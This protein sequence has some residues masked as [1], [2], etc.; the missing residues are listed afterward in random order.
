MSQRAANRR[1]RLVGVALTL[2][3]AAALTKAAWVQ[4]GQASQFSRRA[5]AQQTAE[6]TIEASRGSI[7]DRNNVELASNTE[8]ITIWADPKLVRSPATA[9][10]QAARVLGLKNREEGKLLE[11]LADRS[12][13]FVYV[14]RQVPPETAARLERLKI[15]GF[16]FD[17]DP[18]RSYPQR[19]LAAQVLGFTD[20]DSRGIAGLEL[21]YN[22]Q[23]TGKDGSQIVER[24]PKGAV[25]DVLSTEDEQPGADLTLT[26]DN[27]IQLGVQN[28]LKK[29]LIDQGARSASAV[30][31]DAHSGAVLAMET[32]PSYDANETSKAPLDRQR[33]RAVTDNYEPGSTFKLVTVAGALA[34]G[35]VSPY[36]RFT[37]PYSIPVAD[38]TIHDAHWR[39]TERMSVAEILSESSNV[40]AV[41]I[42]QLLGAERLDRWISAFGFGKR[43]GID[44]PGESPGNVRPLSEWYGSAVG[45]IPIG[46]GIAV[47]QIQLAAAYAAIANDGVWVQPRLVERIGDEAAP[48]PKRRR[49]VSAAV[50]DQLMSMLR[51]VVIEG[52]ATLAEL[53]NYTVA[54][55]T[56]TAEQPDNFGGYSGRYVASFVG[57]APASNPRLVI[58]VTVDQPNTIWGAVAAAPAF[59]QIALDCLR[60]LEV[61]PDKRS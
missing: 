58:L 43:T 53:P 29:T 33:N 26:L 9:S 54:G 37:L 38:K 56:G 18:K 1:I 45:T 59:K 55:K 22:D 40:G 61:P 13:R 2:A 25:I 60:Y 49:V 19:S 47:T 24:D 8:A 10:M 46:Q 50:A 34:D 23:L 44:F 57:I 41:K 14:A 6:I 35:V 52:T 48:E 11:A 5:T 28:E 27:T 39:R 30:V 20:P 12:K 21:K 32:V 4:V 51:D 36:T 42:S 3:L 17:E 15:R 16:G 31:L 7:V